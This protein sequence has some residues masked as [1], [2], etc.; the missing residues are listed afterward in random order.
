MFTFALVCPL[1]PSV[2]VDFSFVQKSLQGSEIELGFVVFDVKVVYVLVYFGDNLR[3]P[4]FN[5]VK[6]SLFW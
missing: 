3:N 6:F 1:H 4:V 2:E 5:F